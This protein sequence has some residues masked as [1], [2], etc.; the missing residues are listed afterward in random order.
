MDTWQEPRVSKDT[1]FM[2]WGATAKGENFDS[3]AKED[4]QTPKVEN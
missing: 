2:G 4:A 3:V 1:I